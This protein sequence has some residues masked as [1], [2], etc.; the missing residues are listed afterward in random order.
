MS[1]FHAVGTICALFIG[2]S[3]PS[4]ALAQQANNRIV[5]RGRLALQGEVFDMR[6]EELVLVPF[7]PEKADPDDDGPIHPQ[8]LFVPITYVVAEHN[9][10]RWLYG[11]TVGDDARRA[12]LESI[13]TREIEDCT[14]WDFIYRGC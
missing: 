6:N 11:A 13:L 5:I 8:A 12:R 7:Q 9:F 10:E 4:P 14:F 2:W 1:R 3:L